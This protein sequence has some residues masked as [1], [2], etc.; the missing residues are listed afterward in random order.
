MKIIQARPY[1]FQLQLESCALVVIDMQ[2]DFVESGGF[3]E[4]LGNDVSILQDI[5]PTVVQL[6]AIWRELSGLVIHTREVHLPD[7]SNCP[8]AKIRRGN[9]TTKIGDLGPM[10]RLLIAGEYGS[11]IIEPLLPLSGEV[12]IDKPGKGAFYNTDLGKILNERGI[13][14]LMIVGVTTEVCVQTTMRE[15]NDR[16]FDCLLIEDATAS[17]FPEFKQSTIE[18]IVAQG[19]IVGWTT[20]LSNLIQG[21]AN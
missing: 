7:L 15:A 14:Q 21:L 20:P 12:V 17:Y 1:D 5:V 6:L 19:G 18:M 11:E 13:T 10:G 8:P 4:A 2:R 3:G 9:L 16:G